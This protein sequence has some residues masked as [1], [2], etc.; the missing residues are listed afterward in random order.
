LFHD[1]TMAVPTAPFKR[2]GRR[3]GAF[4][5][6]NAQPLGH[7]RT[8]TTGQGPPMKHFDFF[9]SDETIAQTLG[10]SEQFKALEPYSSWFG[11]PIWL[12]VA[13]FFFVLEMLVPPVRTSWILAAAVV[14]GVVVKLGEV[15]GWGH[16]SLG[17][18]VAMFVLT[19]ALAFGVRTAASHVPAARVVRG[20]VEDV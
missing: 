14:T 10:V 16:F 17:E 9:P 7:Y 18:Q 1:A 8:R 15:Y 13:G 11:Y 6:G 19:A 12:A 5:A 4:S 20:G 3:R 2:L